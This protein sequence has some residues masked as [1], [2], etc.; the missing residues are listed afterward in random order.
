MTVAQLLG[1]RLRRSAD[2]DALRQSGRVVHAVEDGVRRSRARCCVPSTATYTRLPIGNA[3]GVATGLAQRVLEQAHLV[4]EVRRGRGAR[5]DP[6][7]AHPCRAVQRRRAARPEPHRRPW[8]LDGLG[9]ER[10][11]RKAVEVA[12]IGRLAVRPQAAEDLDALLQAACAVPRRQSEPGRRGFL[13]PDAD[14][15]DQPAAAQPIDRRELPRQLRRVA[16]GQDDHGD[17]QADRAGD[18]RRC[19]QDVQPV[20]Q[21]NPRGCAA[22]DAVE[23]P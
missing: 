22:R 1:A 3:S 19:R 18:R 17:A 15:D 5:A 21:R 7:I 13:A 16:G 10:H 6:A 14:A 11:A 23:R 8:P 20:E 9:L 4:R 2:C 12:V